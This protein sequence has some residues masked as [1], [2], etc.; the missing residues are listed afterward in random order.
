VENLKRKFDAGEVTIEDLRSSKSKSLSVYH[1]FERSESD[2][3]D[4]TTAATTFGASFYKGSPIAVDLHGTL[5]GGLRGGTIPTACEKA[6]KRLFVRGFQP[7]ILT[8]IGVDSAERR[9]QAEET[10]KYLAQA[11]GLQTEIPE[12]PSAHGLYLKICGQR[13][14]SPT[15]WNSGKW[16]ECRHQGTSVLFDDRAIII[17]ECQKADILCIQCSNRWNFPKAVDKFLN[18]EASGDLYESFEDA[19]ITREW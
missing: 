10:R 2:E 16:F 17:K 11:C 7:W 14:S 6:L 18:D 13:V 19:W 9:A 3:E 8:Y 5:D 15:N 1:F 12:G 4:D